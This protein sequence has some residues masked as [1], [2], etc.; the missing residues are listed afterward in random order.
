LGIA[1]II[2][3]AFV[4]S[5]IARIPAAYESAMHRSSLE[6]AGQ[7]MASGETVRVQQAIAAYNGEATTGST[8]SAAS[9]MWRVLTDG[10]SH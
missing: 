1:S 8:F 4:I 10:P 9:D 7:L 2:S 5:E 3:I 6:L